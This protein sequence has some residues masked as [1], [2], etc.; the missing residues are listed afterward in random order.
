MIIEARRDVEP[1]VQALKDAGLQIKT[2]PDMRG[3][4]YGKLLFNLNNVSLA[5]LCSVTSPPL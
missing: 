5:L 2:H 1:L 3:V 4:L